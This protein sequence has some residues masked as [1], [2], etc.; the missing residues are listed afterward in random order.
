[1]G[2]LM[3][4]WVKLIAGGYETMDTDPSDANTLR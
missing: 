3:I 4:L 2:T 1:M